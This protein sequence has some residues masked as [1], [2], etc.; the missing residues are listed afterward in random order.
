MYRIM[1]FVNYWNWRLSWFPNSWFY[2]DSSSLYYGSPDATA[3]PEWILKNQYGANLYINWLCGNGVC[4]QYVPDYSNENFRQWWIAQAKAGMSQGFTGIFVDDVNFVM[5][6]SNGTGLDTP[7]DPNT[8]QPM[9][10]QAWEKYF[11]DFLTE[12]RNAFPN[13]EICH[14]ALWYA[15]NFSPLTDPYVQQEIKAANYIN[16]ERG[17]ADSGLTNTGSWGIQN[18]FSYIDA[19]HSL[20]SRVL[21]EQYGFDGQFSLASYFLINGGNDL[22]ANDA[23][24]PNNWPSMYDVDLGTPLGARRTWNGLIRRDFSNGIALINPPNSASVTVTLPGSFTD[25]NGNPLTTITLGGRQGAVLLGTV[26]TTGPLPDGTYQLTNAYSQLVM[27]D[28]NQSMQAGNQM[29]QWTSN[30]GQNQ[31]WSFVWDGSGYY[32]IQNMLS[33]LYLTSGA[34]GNS[35]LTQQALGNN[36][37]QLWSLKTSGSNYVL[38]NKATGLAIDDPAY[39]KTTG[40]GLILWSPN[41]GVNQNWQIK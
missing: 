15:G 30:G 10:T 32:T 2:R 25:L 3:H 31:A 23:V 20:G 36:A 38:I 19:V 33:K 13:A 6:L 27:D 35:P 40:T 12:I 11:A 26:R 22:L 4:S 17:F 29:I 7:I 24:T 5:N 21:A 18:L 1:G 14:N 41:G 16:L 39:S 37:T 9:T 28:A 34:S 8:G